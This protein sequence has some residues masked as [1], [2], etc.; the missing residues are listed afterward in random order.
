MPRTAALVFAL[1]A[2]GASLAAMTPTPFAELNR[3][4]RAFQESRLLLS[5]VELD[6]FTAVGAGATAAEVAGKIKTDP[7][8]TE[9]FLNALVAVGALTK[10][11]AQFRNT[12]DTARYLTAGSPD[13]ARA[14][15]M[16]TVR[17]WEGW[18]RLTDSV[19]QGGAAAEPGVEAHDPAW[20]ESF[21]AAMHRGAGTA[22]QAVV[23]AVG[24]AGVRRMLDIGG[25]SGAYAMAFAEANPEMRAEVLDLAPVVEIARRHIREARLERRVTARVGDLTRDDFGSGYDLVLLSS[26]CHML[27][28]QQN[29]D[30]L[31]RVYQA[32]APGGRV[33]IRDFILDAG[34][35]SPRG[36]ALF[37]VHML[38]QTRGGSTYSEREYSEWLRAAGF[39]RVERLDPAG[40]LIIGTR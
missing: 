17:T 27:D 21:I 31:R 28:E 5:A 3:M 22:A 18:H 2:A 13:D 9:T 38:V 7:R 16:H 10:D 14:A 6:V 33:V 11:G 30:L 40:D 24:A 26:I 23:K 37:A 39:A 29:R 35:T 34:K 32:L 15:L 20:T 4:M 36:A 1:L 8:A 19:R 25:G 12:P